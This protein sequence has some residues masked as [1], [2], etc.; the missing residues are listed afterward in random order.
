MRRYILC[1]VDFSVDSSREVWGPVDPASFFEIA[2]KSPAM[3]DGGP[4]FLH[5]MDG[6]YE[7]EPPAPLR[8][9]IRLP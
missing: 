5:A 9:A 4:Y 3:S 7:F 6:L 1:V 8:P 2:K